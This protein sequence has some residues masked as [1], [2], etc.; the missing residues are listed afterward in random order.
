MKNIAS[1]TILPTAEFEILEML[2]HNGL[3][4]TMLDRDA[5]SNP[6]RLCHDM[7]AEQLCHDAD[8]EQGV[9]P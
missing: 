4:V 6:V 3:R 2:M 9:I 1:S 5:I 7:I 8:E